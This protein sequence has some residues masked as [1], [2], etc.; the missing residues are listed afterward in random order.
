MNEI[1]FRELPFSYRVS[2]FSA[3]GAITVAIF[4]RRL[5][6]PNMP[7]QVHATF[8]AVVIA[9]IGISLLA[10]SYVVIRYPYIS[11]IETADK[12][13]FSAT[14]SSPSFKRIIKWLGMFASLVLFVSFGV[15]GWGNGNITLG[16]AFRWV[17][18][19]LLSAFVFYLSIFYDPVEHPTI[20][21]F[22]RATLGIGIVFAPIFA[23]I[24]IVGC[25]RCG[26]MLDSA[27]KP[28]L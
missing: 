26:K 1:A 17:Y 28:T 9:I 24:L 5:N 7:W 6:L 19:L 20:A 10:T 16:F 18:S 25:Y 14:F 11:L 15:L 4:A 8:A 21:T 12:D 27:N 2:Q 23:P 13:I 3:L 22:I